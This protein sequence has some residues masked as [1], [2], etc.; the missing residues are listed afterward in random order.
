MG[1]RVDS[2][3]T[4]IAPDRLCSPSGYEGEFG[5]IAPFAMAPS[6]SGVAGHQPIRLQPRHLCFQGFGSLVE[7]SEDRPPDGRQVCQPP[8]PIVGLD[9]AGPGDPGRAEG[10]QGDLLAVD[11]PDRAIPFDDQL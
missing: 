11:A 6:T 8:T 2:W 10:I 7:W 3:G 5:A 1:S 4:S 9:V